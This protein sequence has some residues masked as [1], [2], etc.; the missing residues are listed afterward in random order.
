MRS[1]PNRAGTQERGSERT[2]G[3]RIFAYHGREVAKKF[4]A[5]N[6]R[7]VGP[8]GEHHY[9]YDASEIV[10]KD[11]QGK[12]K[13]R[14]EKWMK[15]VQQVAVIGAGGAGL[16]ALRHL[17]GQ[18]GLSVVAY[19]LSSQIGGTWVYTDKT[20]KDE[21]GLPI[22]SSMYEHMRTNLPKEVM[23]F[24]DFP[25]PEEDASFLH[26]TKVLE[27]LEGYAKHFNL[28]KHYAVPR[29]PKIPGLDS[30]KGQ[31]MHSHDYR[32]SE[33]FIDKK[34]FILGA[35]PSGLDISIELAAVTPCVYLSHKKAPL[36]TRLPKN[37][38]QI[39]VVERVE[40]NSFVLPDGNRVEADVL[41]VCTGY[42]YS[43]PFL[44]PDCGIQVTDNRVEPLY[45]HCIHINH[46][47]SMFFV[48]IPFTVCPFPL[49][50]FQG[51]L[52]KKLLLEGLELPSSKEMLSDGEAEWSKRAAQGFP[53][54]RYHCMHGLFQDYLDS[55]A[56]WMQIETLPPAFTSLYT[57]IFNS[58]YH[59]SLADLKERRFRLLL[60]VKQVLTGELSLPC[61]EEMEE[62]I[63]EEMKLKFQL[64]FPL[65]HYH[66]M[67]N[68][69]WSYNDA[70]ADLAKCQRLARVVCDLYDTVHNIRMLDVTS[71]KDINFRL[72]GNDS[73]ARI[74]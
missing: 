64:G 74:S 35:G 54:H 52:A 70:M 49:F 44:D 29:M 60:V 25:F 50:H 45:K 66:K 15:A 59:D 34:V 68:L 3:K 71:Y 33:P 10:D 56:Q 2:E 18:P 61:R 32:N 65:H 36:K 43:F 42:E 27:Y 4:F 7:K 21:H 23:A 47:Q 19:E 31:V 11:S 24:P 39:P 57:H 30:Y 26:H 48:G 38:V 37:V 20:G 62:D 6:L 12:E 51:L 9:R 22:H 8:H 17:A 16:A 28:Y 46:P 72:T 55:L 5:P 41:L 67:G 1:L 14:E 40:E 53:K 58:I 73:F 63:K 13:E 69:Q